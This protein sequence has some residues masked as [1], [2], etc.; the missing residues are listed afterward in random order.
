MLTEVQYMHVESQLGFSIMQFLFDEFIKP[1]LWLNIPWMEWTNGTWKYNRVQFCITI[2]I[3]AT[4]NMSNST[5]AGNIFYKEMYKT[6][7]SW[8]TYKI[9]CSNY[10]TECYNISESN[11]MTEELVLT[12]PFQKYTDLRMR[13]SHLNL[14][15]GTLFLL[16]SE[17]NW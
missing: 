14:V 2:S 5:T 10:G 16:R 8:N 13:H 4:A 12:L 7:Q 11:F 15:V 3:C 9:P 6:F 1:F 17:Y